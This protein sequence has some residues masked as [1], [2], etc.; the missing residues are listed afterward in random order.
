MCDSQ[1]RFEVYKAINIWFLLSEIS[2]LGCCY[3]SGG[4][5][6]EP[7]RIWLANGNRLLQAYC[8]YN[9]VVIDKLKLALYYYAAILPKLCCY[10]PEAKC[11]FQAEADLAG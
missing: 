9:A 8:I 7:S 2:L 5:A 4:V 10:P 1:V 6:S 11:C 3:F